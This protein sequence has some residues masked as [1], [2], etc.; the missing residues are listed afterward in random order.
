MEIWNERKSEGAR[1]RGR[2]I[3]ADI[4][5]FDHAGFICMHLIKQTRQRNR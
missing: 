5:T 3:E 4:K 1:E 2:V